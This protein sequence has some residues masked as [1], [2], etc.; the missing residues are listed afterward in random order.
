[1]SETALVVCPGRGTY[2]AGELGHLARHGAAYAD[3]LERFDA[4]RQRA[5]RPGVRELDAAAAFSPAVHTAG[6]HAAALIYACSLVDFLSLDC[7]RFEVVAVTGNSMGWYTAL[8]L[9]GALTHDD[10]FQLADTMGA[11]MAQGI[12]GGQLVYPEVDARWRPDPEAAALLDAALAEANAEPGAQAYL[13][14]RFG[15]YRVL[16]GNEAGLKALARRLP[17]RDERFPMRLANHAAFH[18]PLM[19]PTSPRAFDHV[20]PAGF[21]TP[22]L[23]LI[24]GRGHVWSPQTSDPEALY[25]YTL[26]HQVVEPF[27]FTQ[28]IAVGLKEFA[29]ERVVVLGPGTT[30]GGAIGQVLVALRWHG[31]DAKDAFDARQ[32]ADPFL[33]SMGRDDQRARVV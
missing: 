28:A 7:D 6:E 15:S 31:I 21:R 13:S 32:A 27:D 2:N 12:V 9:G 23:P 29:P 19:A 20:P 8:A 5:G 14:I 25:R 22:A 10:G 18:T 24:D 1:M 30:L 3:A 33:L 17:E 16:A 26:G 4:A 11:M